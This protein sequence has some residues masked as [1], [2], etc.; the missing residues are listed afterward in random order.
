VVENFAA[1]EASD[2]AAFNERCVAAMSRKE[3]FSDPVQK[4]I[5]LAREHGAKVVLVEMPMPSRHRNL[6]YS[7]EA[8]LK[9]RW[10]LQ[11]VAAAN[12][13]IYLSASDWVQD[14]GKFEDVTHLNEAGA[15]DFSAQLARAM[16]K[17]ANAEGVPSR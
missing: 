10:H 9:L 5:H 3:G 7:T 8:W 15:K 12:E 4:M 17:L 16:A 6:F 11:S 2:A 14:D 13:A 1:L